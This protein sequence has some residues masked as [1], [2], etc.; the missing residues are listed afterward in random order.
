[1]A[2]PKTLHDRQKELQALLATQTGRAHLQAL[3]YQLQAETGRVNPPGKSIITYIL[4]REREKGL[5]VG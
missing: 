4:T 1:M 3:R 5:I 2:K